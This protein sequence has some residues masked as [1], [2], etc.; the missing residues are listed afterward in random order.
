MMLSQ[1]REGCDTV[2]SQDESRKFALQASEMAGLLCG[3]GGVIELRAL[4]VTPD[5][6]NPKPMAGFFDERTI[7]KDPIYNPLT[8]AA[9]SITARAEGVYCTQNP[10]HPD[11]LARCANRVSVAGNDGPAKDVDIVTRRWLLIDIDP[12]RR[13]KISASDTEKQ[14]AKDVV[15]TVAASLAERGWPVPM[16][17]DSGNGYHLYYRIDLPCDDG[18][19]V[20]ACLT[21]LADKFDT[22]G[23][24]VDPAVFNPSRIVKLPGT[25]ARKGDSIPDRPHRRAMILSRPDEFAAVPH[26]LL[27]AL[28]AEAPKPAQRAVSR[29]AGQAT[30]RAQRGSTSVAERARR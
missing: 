4:N 11:L 17:I 7:L 12:V 2:L 16:L 28:A 19:L 27:D 20:K 10:V 26:E 25:L 6:G 5:Y 30:P 9:V 18:G 24:I 21:A 1:S 8:Q 14:A 15:D 22:D 23:A 13:S 29:N 3:E